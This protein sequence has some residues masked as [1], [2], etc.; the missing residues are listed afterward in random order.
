V[1]HHT[2]VQRLEIDEVALLPVVHVRGVLLDDRSWWRVTS[3]HPPDRRNRVLRF[4]Q[5]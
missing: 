3:L 4:A 1:R 5:A 2:A